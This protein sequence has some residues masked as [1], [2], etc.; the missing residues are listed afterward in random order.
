MEINLSTHVV[1]GLT[2][3][4]FA[5]A[6]KLDAIDVEYSPKWAQAEAERMAANAAVPKEA[7]AE[8]SAV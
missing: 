2:R 6:A 8:A 3:P 7:K 1:G 4:D 5:L